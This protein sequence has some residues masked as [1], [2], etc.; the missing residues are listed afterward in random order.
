MFVT[1]RLLRRKRGGS[2]RRTARPEGLRQRSRGLGTRRQ[3]PM[4]PHATRTER[5]EAQKAEEGTSNSRLYAV[6]ALCKQTSLSVVVAGI[7]ARRTTSGLCL[8]AL[9]PV[10]ILSARNERSCCT[11]TRGSAAKGKRRDLPGLWTR[12]VFR[13][14]LTER[15]VC[16]RGVQHRPMPQDLGS[17]YCSGVTTSEWPLDGLLQCCNAGCEAAAG[18]STFF[19]AATRR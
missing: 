17:R 1:L 13:A 10:P 12:T 19:G 7:P 6:Y 11:A 5:T 16:L 4:A 15:P 2:A 3:T 9:H 18:V 8:R 14:I